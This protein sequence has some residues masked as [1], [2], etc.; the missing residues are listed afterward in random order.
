[1][2]AVGAACSIGRPAVSERRRK[3]S[4]AD[5][6]MLQGRRC[7][8]DSRAFDTAAVNAAFSLPFAALRQKVAKDFEMYHLRRARPG[9]P[10]RR[11]A[12]WAKERDYTVIA[13]GRIDPTPA[14]LVYFL[15]VS[16]RPYP[17]MVGWS[18]PPSAATTPPPATTAPGWATSS[19]TTST[20]TPGRSS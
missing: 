3:L 8:G 14:Q 19:T 1:L 13:I 11:R 7:G 5:Q 12:D 10:L 20:S 18:T 4:D 17:L 2:R 6:R 15:R 16:R 9:R